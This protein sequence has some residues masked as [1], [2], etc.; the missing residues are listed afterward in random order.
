MS[1]PIKYLW[2]WRKSSALQMLLC[3]V[4]LGGASGPSVAET[5]TGNVAY[6]AESDLLTIEANNLSLREV[7]ARVAGHTGIRITLPPDLERSVTITIS[8]PPAEV[9]RQLLRGENYA[10]TYEEHG[11][12]QRLAAVSV[13]PKGEQ[14][15][16]EPLTPMMQS[17]SPSTAQIYSAEERA[18]LNRRRAARESR[19]HTKKRPDAARSPSSRT[20]GSAGDAPVKNP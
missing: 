2:R 11:R 14:G 20:A 19:D 18:E 10:L 8:K 9:V 17:S 1:Y 15:V 16:V 7:L 12:V 3:I 4:L 6:Q 5:G 13:L